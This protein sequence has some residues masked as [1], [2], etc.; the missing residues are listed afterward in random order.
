[1]PARV[2]SNSSTTKE[3]KVMA[4]KLILI[5][6]FGL[7]V[8]LPL[9]SN[10]NAACNAFYLAV[11]GICIQ[12]PSSAQSGSVCIKSQVLKIKGDATEAQPSFEVVLTIK[13]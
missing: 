9:G 1:M 3:G 12:S 5:G 7:L 2:A 11:Y 4:K 13:G 6:L 10:A 8:I